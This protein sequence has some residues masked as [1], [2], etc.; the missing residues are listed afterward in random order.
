ME[1]NWFGCLLDKGLVNE[2]NLN[3]VLLEMNRDIRRLAEVELDVHGLV[4][5]PFNFPLKF[6]IY[7][8]FFFSVD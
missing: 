3:E 8:G 4:F 2:Y 7:F 5:D 1:V 6:K